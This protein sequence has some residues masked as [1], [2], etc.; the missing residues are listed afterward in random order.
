MG[1]QYP[2]SNV[3]LAAIGEEWLFHILLNNEG[4]GAYCIGAGMDL[5]DL[6]DA[7]RLFYV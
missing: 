7:K 5:F 3:K 4:I 1:S 6:T 2:E